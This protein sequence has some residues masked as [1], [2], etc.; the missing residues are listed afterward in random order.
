MCLVI[1]RS[2]NVD[3]GTEKLELGCKFLAKALGADNISPI[4]IKHLGGK[5]STYLTDLLNLS[6]KI[7][8][9]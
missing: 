2:K 4:L 9:L 1:V 7:R 6:M 3:G 5:A 8:A